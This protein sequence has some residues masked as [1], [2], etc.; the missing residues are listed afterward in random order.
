M[1]EITVVSR[2]S[3]PSDWVMSQITE[4]ATTKLY[5]ITILSEMT[6]LKT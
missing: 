1:Q 6:V 4:I 5:N 3:L 2:F